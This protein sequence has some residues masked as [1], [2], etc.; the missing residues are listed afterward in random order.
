MESGDTGE[1]YLPIGLFTEFGSNGLSLRL[2]KYFPSG[3]M[4]YGLWAKAEGVRQRK[5]KRERIVVFIT[6][7]LLRKVFVKTIPTH[8]GIYERGYF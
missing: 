2:P 3:D 6:C 4:M 1:P 5:I 8:A 7:L